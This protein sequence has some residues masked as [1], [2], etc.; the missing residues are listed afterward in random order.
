MSRRLELLLVSALLLFLE[1]ACIRWLPAHVLFLG[2]FT[3]TVLFASFLGMSAGG[4][5]A[6]R[7]GDALVFTPI[8]L[9][10]TMLAAHGVE[11]RLAAR[12]DL[13]VAVGERTP[14]IVYFGA[15]VGRL[16]P[17]RLVVPVEWIAG[18][19]FLATALVFVGLGQRLGRALR[20]APDPL[21]GYALNLLGSLAGI[22]LFG[23]ASWA[24][25]G[26]RV[27][28]LAVAAALASLLLAARP[29]RPAL[30]AAAVLPLAAV[31]VLADRPA[32]AGRDPEPGKPGGAP[33]RYWSPYYRIDYWPTPAHRIEV[34]LVLHQLMQSR[35]AGVPG[36][37]LPHELNREAGRPPFA[38]VLVIGAGSGNDVD[39]ALA[40]GASRVDAVEIDP[41][42]L[43]LGRRDHPDR[44]YDDPRVHVYVD[45]GRSFLRRTDRRYDLVVYALVDS[46]V[47]H[48]GLGN[49]RLESYL[50]TREAID[51]VRRRLKPG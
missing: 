29:L 16:D 38:D 20:A 25:L 42:I 36:Y 50:F 15:E 14:E 8:L 22:A 33:E 28:F 27:W 10:A 49:L 18:F 37:A 17:A 3:N 9:A 12:P 11:E 6:D 46:L 5:A 1:L 30:A 24:E 34:N 47:L 2:Y 19:F 21:G 4:L 23:L 44:P 35:E 32:V 13:Q 43:R 26:P 40:A 51:D 39:R 31:V 48:S 7:K 41:V 45:D